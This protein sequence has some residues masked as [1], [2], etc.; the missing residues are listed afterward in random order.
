MFKKNTMS[1]PLLSLSPVEECSE[2]SILISN[3][4]EVLPKYE[5]KYIESILKKNNYDITNT[6]NTILKLEEEEKDFEYAKSL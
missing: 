6:I 1:E 2:Q 3:I 5:D 4:K